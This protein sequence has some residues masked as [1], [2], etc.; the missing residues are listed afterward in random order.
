[1]EVDIS[2]LLNNAIRSFSKEYVL[3]VLTAFSDTYPSLPIVSV[4]S[5]NGYIESQLPDREWLLVDPAPLSYDL[6]QGCINPKLYRKPDYRYTAELIKF[7]P[8]LSRG[9]QCLLFL[10]W[11]NHGEDNY[12]LTA[13]KLLKPRAVLILHEPVGGAGST[14]LNAFVAGDDD[15]EKEFGYRAKHIYKIEDPHEEFKCAHTGLRMTWLQ[16]PDQLI[17]MKNCPL[18]VHTL[19]CRQ[20]HDRHNKVNIKL[21]SYDGLKNLKPADLLESFRGLGDDPVRLNEAL[22]DPQ[23]LS[24]MMVHVNI[25]IEALTQSK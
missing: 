20:K 2:K 14:Q 6:K 16:R 13:I 7:K 5:G 23:K 22:S 1:M 9:D 3:E 21:N 12:D 4:G 8:S 15:E 19:V 24:D 11:T 17:M 18:Q 25:L 10:N